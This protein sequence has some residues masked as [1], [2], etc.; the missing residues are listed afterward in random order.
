MKT[1]VLVK[2]IRKEGTREPIGKVVGC[3][4]PVIA[5]GK[6]VKNVWNIGWS[7]CHKEDKYDSKIAHKIA[8]GRAHSLK[9]P[10]KVLDSFT[11]R[12]NA[13]NVP[14]TIAK[15][16]T[17]MYERCERYF[18]GDAQPAWSLVNMTQGLYVKAEDC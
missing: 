2:Y 15:E 10:Q 5:D 18:K 1:D 11:D 16:I 3:L 13:P 8:L 9:H 12:R 6:H 7:L 4:V 14:H 17:K